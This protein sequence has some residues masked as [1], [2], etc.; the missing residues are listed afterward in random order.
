MTLEDADRATEPASTVGRVESI[1]VSRGGLPKRPIAEADVTTNGLEGDWQS[2]R[3]YHGGPDR[4]VVIF[5]AERIA[6]LQAEGH[7]IGTGTTGENLT[8]SGLEWTEVVP[9]ARLAIG[10]VRLEVTKFT[11]PCVNI[12]GSFTGRDIARLSQKIRPGWSRVCAR[13]LASGRIRVG[14]AVR[15]T[16]AGRGS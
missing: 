9:G 1:N 4:A 12:A 7:P 2:D 6:A 8:L 11:T 13:V 10:E 15:L 3:R 14:D 5:S 16:G